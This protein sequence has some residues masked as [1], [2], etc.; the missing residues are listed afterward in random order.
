VASIF[1]EGPER[2]AR[3]FVERT[4]TAT[5]HYALDPAGVSSAIALAHRGDHT[6]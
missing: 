3:I 6:L 2:R 5:F 1:Y 4:R